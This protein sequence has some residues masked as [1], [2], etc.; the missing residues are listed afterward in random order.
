[1]SSDHGERIIKIEKENLE[2]VEILLLYNEIK[3][4][5]QAITLIAPEFSYR[6]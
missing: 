1:M 3:D 4:I 5:P 2:N 6:T